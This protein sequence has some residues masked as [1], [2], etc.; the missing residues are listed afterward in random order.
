M[1]K[2][3]HSKLMGYFVLLS[4]ISILLMSIAF[5]F[6]FEDC[7]AIY[8]DNKRNDEIERFMNVLK[9][10]VP[11]SDFEQHHVIDT[12]K[13]LD[14]LLSYQAVT[15]GLFYQVYNKSGELIL[16]STD[17]LEKLRAKMADDGI[18]V[19]EDDLNL[20]KEKRIL[21]VDGKRIGSVVVH[22]KV[23]YLKGEFQ[24]KE[25]LNRYIIVAEITM[26]IIAFVIS[27]FFSKRLTL[28]LNQIRNVAKELLS[29]NLTVRMPVKKSYGEEMQQVAEAFNEL[30]A[31][32]SHQENLRKQFSSDL[33]HE[34]RTPIATLRSIVEAF[35]DKIWEPTPKRLDQCHNELMRLVHLVDELEKLMAAENPTIQLNIKSINVKQYLEEI[36]KYFSY[37]FSQKNISFSVTVME[38]D[39]FFKADRERLNQIFS[40]LLSNSLKYTAEG[41]HVRVGLYQKDQMVHFYIED[42]G[43]GISKEDLPHVFERFYR[44][45]KSRVRKTGGVGIGLSI[46]NALV[47]AQHGSIVIESELK[48][49]TIV[50]VSFPID[51]S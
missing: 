15:E 32:L 49:G 45:D 6:S 47:Q 38:D 23:G 2:T 1:F 36:D 12:T 21:D 11:P 24:F 48:K 46:V 9:R 28:G 26:V 16:D 44:G 27:F 5:R 10:E 29:H 20:V 33:A 22:Y 25:R 35:Q 51:Y 30:A 7:F 3:L 42:D 31:S 8:L 19:L 4:L 37:Q 13:A 41:G 39:I 40:N 14:T 43:E 17:L 34:F 50:T 18:N